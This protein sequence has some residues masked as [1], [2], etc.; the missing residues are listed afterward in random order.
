MQGKENR[1]RRESLVSQG[2]KSVSGAWAGTGKATTATTPIRQPTQFAYSSDSDSLITPI[3]SNV[4]DEPITTNKDRS[5]RHSL[6][7]FTSVP[8]PRPAQSTSV[9]PLASS[10]TIRPTTPPLSPSDIIPAVWQSPDLERQHSVKRSSTTVSSD[11]SADE[12]GNVVGKKGEGRIK[13]ISNVLRG[14]KGKKNTE[15][16]GEE[17]EKEG[18]KVKGEKLRRKESGWRS[19]ENGIEIERRSGRSF[20]VL[21]RAPLPRTRSQPTVAQRTLQIDLER[22][23]LLDGDV[24]ATMI[25]RTPTP[26]LELIMEEPG[27]LQRMRM[28]R[29]DSYPFPSFVTVGEILDGTTRDAVGS[30]T[31]VLP[32]SPPVDE[33]AGF[34]SGRD[35]GS[36]PLEPISTVHSLLHASRPSTPP[37]SPPPILTSSDDH[38]QDSPTLSEPISHPVEIFQKTT[39]S[40]LHR[41]DTTLRL[42]L[43]R[44][45][46][47]EDSASPLTPDLIPSR[48]EFKNGEEATSVYST[49]LD[50]SSIDSHRPSTQ[51]DAQ[52]VSQ[53]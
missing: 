32:C 14:F 44:L 8:I 45:S 40:P 36:S 1:V 43:D 22:M 17:G 28:G 34:D 21:R 26:N 20:E 11:Y 12:E 2:W 48:R 18:R 19:D 41:L 15:E 35:L 25:P 4:A 29:G 9:L 39:T 30:G 51:G 33:G 13:R 52:P 42:P 49:S 38:S 50:S 46:D 47:R 27:T 23:D 10:T 7:D 53:S 37:R 3:S 5:W 6:A 16:G 31:M 24:S